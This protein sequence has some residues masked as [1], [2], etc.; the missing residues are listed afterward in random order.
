LG[1]LLLGYAPGSFSRHSSVDAQTEKIL[2]AG[3]EIY[4]SAKAQI[5]PHYNSATA[6]VI[7]NRSNGLRNRKLDFT[8]HDKVAVLLILHLRAL[9]L[10]IHVRFR[11]TFCAFIAW[12]TGG[13]ESEGWFHR[14]KDGRKIDRMTRGQNIAERRA[15]KGVEIT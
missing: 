6:I 3:G 7:E 4:K 11:G 10:K 12:P 2:I 5:F 15:G 1:G 9:L 8:I 14:A 13:Y